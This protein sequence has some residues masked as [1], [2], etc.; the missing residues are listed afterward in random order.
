MSAFKRGRAWVAKFQLRSEQ[1]WV[2]GGP[3]DSKRAAQEAERRYRDRLEA[4]RTNESCSS[5]ASRWLEEWPRKAASTRKLYAQAAE[6]FAV[7]FGATPLGEVERLSARS[8]AL[9]APRNI[10]KIIGTMY[11]DARNV[12]KLAWDDVKVR[13][14]ALGTLVAEGDVAADLLE[15]ALADHSGA[16]RAVLLQVEAPSELRDEI[17]SRLRDDP[18]AYLRAMDSQ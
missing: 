15:R 11:E 10:S 17:R 9:G 8:W 18:D 2:P 7:D 5:F 3:W 4:R 16:V 12:Q 6:R 13:R 14:A 1:H